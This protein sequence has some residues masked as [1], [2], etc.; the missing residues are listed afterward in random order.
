MA[1]KLQELGALWLRESANSGK[2][3]TGKIT[4]DGVE[5]KL[6][7]F[8]NKFASENEN[9]PSY[10]IYLSE[11]LAKAEEPVKAAPVAKAAPKKAAA[12]PVPEPADE[13]EE[14]IL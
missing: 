1:E 8:K 11:P 10:R 13:P 5:T 12:K 2:Y 6:V 9:A 4:I 14:D 3:L 7:V